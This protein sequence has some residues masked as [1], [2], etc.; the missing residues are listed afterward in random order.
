MMYIG[1]MCIIWILRDWVEHQLIVELSLQ[2][3]ILFFCSWCRY[4]SLSISAL[5]QSSLPFH[6]RL[7]GMMKVICSERRWLLCIRSV[8]GR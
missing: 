2:L 7:V 3:A 1:I 5:F 8:C 6:V 4:L